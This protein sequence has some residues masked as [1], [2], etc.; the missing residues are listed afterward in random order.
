MERL[1]HAPISSSSLA[2][3][4]AAGQLA[5]Q[6]RRR[7]LILEAL[8]IL[9]EIGRCRRL[10]GVSIRTLRNKITEYSAEGLDIPRH[11]SRDEILSATLRAVVSSA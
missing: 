3:R 2:P 11:E 7:Y 4:P 6:R 9:M 1:S 8:T 5:H 10:L